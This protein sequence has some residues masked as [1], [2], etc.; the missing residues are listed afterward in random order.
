MCI[1]RFDRDRGSSLGVLAFA[2]DAVPPAAEPC[3]VGRR[4]PA[5][6]IGT[7][8]GFAPE[9]IGEACRGLATCLRRNLASG[10]V[11]VAS[12]GACSARANYDRQAC[13]NT[14][15]PLVFEP[16]RR[17]CRRR[18]AHLLAFSL[19]RGSTGPQK[20]LRVEA[21]RCPAGG[22]PLEVKR[23]GT[24]SFRNASTAPRCPQ[25]FAGWRPRRRSASCRKVRAPQGSRHQAAHCSR[26]RSAAGFAAGV[27]YQRCS[28]WLPATTLRLA[29]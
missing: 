21:L 26:S 7:G 1:E 20:G 27:S 4:P 6:S 10:Q 16:L 29:A 24:S 14:G 17:F 11:A 5:R 18:C 19:P 12:L 23:I 25:C 13:G 28:R 8:T 15:S 3:T 22:K 9:G 2:N